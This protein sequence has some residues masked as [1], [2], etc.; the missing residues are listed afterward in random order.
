ML[1]DSKPKQLFTELP[2][3]WFLPKKDRQVPKSVINPTW[4]ILLSGNLQ[5]P[6]LQSALEG[7][8]AVHHWPFDKLRADDGAADE[9][10]GGQMDQGRR[11]SLLS[12]A[13]LR[14]QAIKEQVIRHQS[15]YGV[16]G[17][18]GFGEIGRAHV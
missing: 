15:L 8:H 18:W 2:V 1:D 12:P 7:G 4:F 17:F 14:M 10:R 11:R 6:R 9:G 3:C 5:L 13:L 16:L